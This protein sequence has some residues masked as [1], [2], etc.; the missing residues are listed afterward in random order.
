MISI[1][2]SQL[3]IIDGSTEG[4]A[5]LMSEIIIDGSALR[6]SSLSVDH[7]D[8]NG[9]LWTSDAGLISY[10]DANSQ[11]SIGGEVLT[12]TW[13]GASAALMAAARDANF[14]GA[15]FKRWLYIFSLSGTQVGGPI[16]LESGFCETP[17]INPDPES[18][19]I[20]I[21]VE[22]DGLTL[23]QPNE[24]RYTKTRI[25]SEYPSDTFCDFTASL[26]DKDLFS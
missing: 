18:P 12:I 21:T 22:S 10:S 25:R 20:T 15:T 23:G 1:P 7:T 5:A 16:L 8:G 14:L 4:Y 19:S 26:V 11:N 13:S 24:Y 3:R 6:I 2:P 9:V 17:V